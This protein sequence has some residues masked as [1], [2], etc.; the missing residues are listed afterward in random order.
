MA[1]LSVHPVSQISPDNDVVVA[2]IFIAAPRERVFA[3]LTDPKHVVQ[4]W[5]QKDYFYVNDS[6][7]DVRV[8]GKWSINGVSVKMGPKT[9][10][11]EFLEVD[12]PRRL[13]YTWNPS[14]MPAVTKVLWQLEKRDNGTVVK[15]THSGFASDAEQAKNHSQGWTRVLGWL[16]AYAE[17][18]E[19]VQTRS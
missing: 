11:G 6:Q 4:W 7:M 15:L 8:G 16:Q 19:T 18:G 13:A 10:E 3:A 5:G 1:S 9:L 2:E 14:W 12:P 17:R